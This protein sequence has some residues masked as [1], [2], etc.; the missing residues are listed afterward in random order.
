MASTFA[1][2]NLAFLAFAALVLAWARWRT[3]PGPPFPGP[4]PVGRAFKAWLVVIWLV[5]LALPLAA[6]VADGLAGGHAPVRAALGWYLLLFVAQVAAE[7][8]AWKRWRSPVWVIVPCLFLPWRLFQVAMGLMAVEGPPLSVA[9]LWAL[10]A[11][12]LINIGVHYSNIPNTLRWDH[13]P[14]DADFAALAGPNP[15]REAR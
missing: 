6:L 13:H 2:A 4:R 3:R 14:A 15:F 8:L 7:I 11:L 1:L 12:W 5:G 9:V 10:L